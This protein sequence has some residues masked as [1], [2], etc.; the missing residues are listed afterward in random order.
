MGYPRQDLA[1]KLIGM[2][3]IAFKTGAFMPMVAR[4]ID[5]PD[6]NDA[7]IHV[8][9]KQD[10]KPTYEEALACFDGDGAEGLEHVFR[11]PISSADDG[12]TWLCELTIA[13]ARPLCL[14]H[15]SH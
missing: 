15:H 10:P 14:A 3:V 9:G 1:G 12:M 8:V 7:L 2:I 6:D 13:E 5:Q 11:H 4:V